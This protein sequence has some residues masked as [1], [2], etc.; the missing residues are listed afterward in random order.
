MVFGQFIVGWRDLMGIREDRDGE[1]NPPMVG[2]RDREQIEAWGRERGIIHLRRSA[3]LTSLVVI[4]TNSIS[5]SD[6]AY[7]CAKNTNWLSS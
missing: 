6:V 3:L 2:N 4:V 1:N 7:S 5:Y